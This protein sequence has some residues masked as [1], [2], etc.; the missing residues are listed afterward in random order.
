VRTGGA[1]I[2]DGEM[3][4][5]PRYEGACVGLCPRSAL[6]VL[7]ERWRPGREECIDCMSVLMDMLARLA[8]SRRLGR[9]GRAAGRIPTVRWAHVSFAAERWALPVIVSVC[10]LFIPGTADPGFFLD[11]RDSFRTSRDSRLPSGL[12]A[13]SAAGEDG[14]DGLDGL[15]GLDE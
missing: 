7:A 5:V 3:G 6:R 1:D 14:E 10:L 11:D 4:E 8:V 15:D 13:V 12:W 2:G 9:D